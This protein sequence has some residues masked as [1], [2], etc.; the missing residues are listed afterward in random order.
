VGPDCINQQGHIFASCQKPENRR[1]NGV[2]HQSAYHDKLIGSQFTK[3]SVNSR[4]LKGIGTTLFQNYL[5]VIP[6][7]LPLKIGTSVGG[8]TDPF[9]S[10]G[11]AYLLGAACTGNTTGFFILGFD[12][13]DLCRNYANIPASCPCHNASQ[14]RKNPAVISDARGPFCKE[15]ILLSVNID[16]NTLPPEG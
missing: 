2:F 6:Q 8:K 7:Y 1:L 13:L 3:N 12:M 16:D 11:I 14:I 9:V 4:L 5:V 15:K 10:G